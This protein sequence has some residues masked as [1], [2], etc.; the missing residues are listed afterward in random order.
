MRYLLIVLL[1]GQV[2]MPASAAETC[3]IDEDMAAAF[4]RFANYS[5]DW[6]NSFPIALDV[7]DLKY[8]GSSTA[9][10]ADHTSVAW[11]GELDPDVAIEL[12]SDSLLAQG[13][14]L[15]PRKGDANVQRGFV[16]H[17]PIQID[18]QRTWCRGQEG[19]IDVRARVASIGTVLTL[20]HSASP[21][22]MGCES[23]IAAQDPRSR[24]D[25]GLLRHLPTLVLPKTVDL[26]PFAPSGFG[27]GSR[28]AHADARVRTDMSA[29]EMAAYFESQMADQ[30]WV[31][32]VAFSGSVVSG[33]V[34]RR[35]VDQLSLY[36]VVTAADGGGDQVQLGMRLK[37]L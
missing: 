35:D 15:V 37:P 36:C 30:R 25:S 31:L 20:S 1:T 18:E 6:P 27:G 24:L 32:D 34:W 28:D 14:R 23:L 33:H 19:T 29:S 11:S 13:W 21:G 4:P 5:R 10:H 8:I 17:R 16:A 2:M 9:T 26:Q 12:A 22:G 7:G 3:C